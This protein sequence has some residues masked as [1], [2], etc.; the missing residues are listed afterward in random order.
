MDMNLQLQPNDRII[1]QLLKDFQG[2]A[3]IEDQEVK[4]SKVRYY[5][6]TQVN[7]LA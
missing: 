3:T 7:E 6:Y 2:F 5:R 1:S 4:W